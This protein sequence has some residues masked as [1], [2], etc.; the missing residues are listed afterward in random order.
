MKMSIVEEHHTRHLYLFLKEKHYTISGSWQW[1][2][3]ADT[4]FC[5]D[6][7][8]SITHNEA[9]HAAIKAIVLPT[10]VPALLEQISTLQPAKKANLHFKI[11]TS[12]GTLEEIRLLYTEAFIHESPFPA[13]E[14]KEANLYDKHITA[15]KEYNNNQVELN[16]YRAAEQ[17][18][19]FGVWYLNTETHKVYYSDNVFRIHKEAIIGK[20]IMLFFPDFIKDAAYT[21]FRRILNG[22]TICKP[23]A[24]AYENN[25]SHYETYLVPIKDEKDEVTGILWMQ[26]D[27]AKERELVQQQ[28]VNPDGS[29]GKVNHKFESQA[30][31]TAKEGRVHG[32]MQDST[33]QMDVINQLEESRRLLQS[34]LDATLTGIAVFKCVRDDAGAIIDFEYELVNTVTTKIAGRPLV[35]QRY[36]QLFPNVRT[37]GIFDQFKA[38]VE[39]GQPVD[40]E[41][42]YEGEQYHNWFRIVAVKFNDGLLSTVEDITE[43]KNVEGNITKHVNVLQ[44]SEALVQLGSWEYNIETRIFSWSEGMYRLFNIQPGAEVK[45]EIYLDMVVEEDKPVAKMIV[46]NIKKHFLPFEKMLRLK[47]GNELK[48]MKIKGIVLKDEK[49]VP[50][51]V[52]GVDLDI[53]DLKT[54]EQNL[55][56]LNQSLDEQNKELA[57]KNE[58]LTNFAFIASHDLRE[59]LRKIFV[60]S[61][62]LL[63]SEAEKLSA[64]GKS[65]VGK[66]KTAVVRMNDLI[67]DM[68]ILS[69][70]KVDHKQV[71]EVDLNKII[72]KVKEELKDAIAEKNSMITGPHL[73][74][75]KGVA[76]QMYYLF[77]NLITNALKFQKEGVQ[78]VINISYKQINGSEMAHASVQ[79][80]KEYWQVSVA[81]NGIGFDQKNAPKIFQIFQRLHGNY[82]FPGTGIGLTICK[83]VMEN[84]GGFIDVESKPGEGTIFYC[85][86]PQ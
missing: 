67:D 61:D 7:F 36:L 14:E 70:L 58:E 33:E 21:E 31:V 37:S 35:G 72:H 8:V 69:R 5:S 78:P 77:M 81:D 24:E 30:N 20:N 38:V 28:N 47:V 51:K 68:L 49:G 13:F 66:M 46:D 10:E 60:F 11:I 19:Q 74:V 6:V 29:I 32:T 43:R 23:A 85:Y 22:E 84:H 86:F 12:F 59:P 17:V 82:E 56:T 42:Y 15:E 79:H 53:T 71:Q 27:Q 3:S 57:L 48:I 18:S 75:V 63:Q 26:R 54:A 64:N 1:P 45:P 40:F 25:S 55:I 65:L 73:P 62:W 83:K 34:I 2:F 80:D 4:I 9:Y 41:Q 44:Q 16:T 39:T 52:L 50:S 76:S